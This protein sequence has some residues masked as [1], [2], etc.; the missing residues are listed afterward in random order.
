LIQKDREGK[1]DNKQVNVVLV[2]RLRFKNIFLKNYF[3]FKI[4]IIFSVFKLFWCIDIKNNFLKIKKNI[5]LIYFQKQNF[6]KIIVTVFLKNLK[7]IIM[8][9]Y[10]K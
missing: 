7:K 4:N 10:N 9:K 1:D 5:I 6:K 3:L 8:N 2:I